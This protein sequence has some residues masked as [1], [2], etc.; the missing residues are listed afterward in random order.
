MSLL[1]VDLKNSEYLKEYEAC[2]RKL[3]LDELYEIL[4]IIKKDPSPER[5]QI[6]AARIRELDDGWCESG[7]FSEE[8]KKRPSRFDKVEIKKI[9]PEEDPYRGLGQCHCRKF[10]PEEQ[11]EISRTVND[12]IEKYRNNPP[13]L[14]LK[15]NRIGPYFSSEPEKFDKLGRIGFLLMIFFFCG[16]VFCI[17]KEMLS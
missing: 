1:Q 15:V 8:V 13:P 16:L 12:I 4:D 14:Y 10:S 6:V 7:I 2:I 5:I 11:I 9:S 3:P 17:V